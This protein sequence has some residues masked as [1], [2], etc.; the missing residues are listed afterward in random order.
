MKLMWY[1]FLIY[2]CIWLLVALYGIYE[3]HTQKK[4]QWFRLETYKEIII[5]SIIWILIRPLLL[6][7]NILDELQKK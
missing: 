2:L 6:F 3:W 1:I 4:K 7:S 5:V